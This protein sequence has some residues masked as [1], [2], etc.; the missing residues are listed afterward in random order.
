M[1]TAW[2]CNGDNF[3]A[4]GC[5]PACQCVLVS[6][7]NSFAVRGIG[8]AIQPRVPRLHPTDLFL[9]VNLPNGDGAIAAGD[10]HISIGRADADRQQMFLG[11]LYVSDPAF[12]R[13]VKNL[14]R[15]NF[16]RHRQDL[17]FIVD[18]HSVGA[19]VGFDFE[20]CFIHF[21]VDKLDNVQVMQQADFSVLIQNLD[22]IDGIEFGIAKIAQQF[23]CARVPEAAIALEIT[24]RDQALPR[25][26]SGYQRRVVFNS[27]RRF[28]AM[29]IPD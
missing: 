8:N 3:L 20:I 27:Q 15:P 7:Y 18:G 21:D 6:R 28:F 19:I 13:Q 17:P 4:I 11:N 2:Q 26:N 1:N 12:C 16:G 5:V 23:S 22:C 9:R 14:Y 25:R 10:R 29:S 24:A